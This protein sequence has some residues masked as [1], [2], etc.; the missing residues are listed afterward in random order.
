MELFPNYAAGITKKF[1]L[2]AFSGGSIDLPVAGEIIRGY[3]ASIMVGWA[4]MPRISTWVR[5]HAELEMG[6][7]IFCSDCA[8]ME[9]S[10]IHAAASGSGLRLRLIALGCA[11]LWSLLVGIDSATASLDLLPLPPIN[12][13]VSTLTTMATIAV[14]NN[15]FMLYSIVSFSS[16]C[17]GSFIKS[18]LNP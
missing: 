10:R 18:A 13:V 17:F 6:A 2:S 9:L 1:R 5:K 4:L 7:R 15:V 14:E 3:R 11:E 12:H 8:V 16:Y